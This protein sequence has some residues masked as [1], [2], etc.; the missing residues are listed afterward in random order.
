MNRHWPALLFLAATVPSIADSWSVPRELIETVFPFGELEVTRSIDGRGDDNRGKYWVDVTRGDELIARLAGIGFE[1]SAVSPDGRFFAGISNS[2]LPH[3]AYFVIDR[4][5]RLVAFRRHSFDE[6][7]YC[8]FSMTV[9]RKWSDSESPAIN[10][11]TAGG[12]HE[13]ITTQIVVAG[14]DGR[15][16]ALLKY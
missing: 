9:S 16:V 5:G 8:D 1:E 10:F 3:T 14:C 13:R 12:G 7:H 6:F 2:G 11:V 15:E 4:D